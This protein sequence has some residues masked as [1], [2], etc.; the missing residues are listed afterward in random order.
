MKTELFVPEGRHF[1][2]DAYHFFI[3]AITLYSKGVLND[4]RLEGPINVT[5]NVN[6]VDLPF[7]ETIRDVYGRYRDQADAQSLAMAEQ[8]LSEAGLEPIREALCNAEHEITCAINAA[9][10]AIKAKEQL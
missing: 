3:A 7:A 10:A 4:A 2:D 8:L 6:G 5:F 9:V 1:D